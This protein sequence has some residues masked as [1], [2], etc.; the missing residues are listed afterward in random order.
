MIQFLNL[1]KINAIHRE[2]LID[3]VKG[4]IDSGSYILGEKVK[5]FEKKFSE[6][7]GVSH[8]VGT[9]NGL[10]ALTL[11]FRS[12]KE[13]GA[14]KDNDEVLVPANTYIATILAITE[15][16]LKPILIEPDI[17]SSQI[18]IDFL[19]K[20]I[21]K[22]TKALIVVHLYGQI[23][24]SDDII[25]IAKKHKLI[26]I[27]DCAQAAG[28]IYQGKKAGSLG[29]A[30]G[31]SFYPS[32]NLGALGDAGAITTS[33]KELAE[34]A[35]ALRNY[36][37]HKKYHNIFKGVNSRLD[38]IQA[39]VLLV[40]LKYLDQENSKRKEIAKLYLKKIKNDKLK[41]P[42]LNSEES[43]VWHLF[44]LRTANRD[45][46]GKFLLKNGIEYY[47]HYPIPPHFQPA[48]SE[49][50]NEKFPAS[51]EIH[52]TTISLPLDISMTADEIEKVIEVCNAY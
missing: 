6:Y 31:F 3:V 49:W 44:A 45:E 25:R 9:G 1:K 16:N 32:K 37:S 28:A 41:M 4:V 19:K 11:I 43:H 7:C 22:K 29:D 23:D 33:N 12:Y 15:N 52:K 10:D 30:A 14:L 27:E 18:N 47:I 5:D 8:T 39:A 50:K 35:R 46:F 21:N 24:F 42:T 38:E 34:I 13:M 51:E 40:K 26:I 48:F 17:A 36:G 20:S 2:E